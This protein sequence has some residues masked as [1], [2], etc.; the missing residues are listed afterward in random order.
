[1]APRNPASARVR[2]A[3][4]PATSKRAPRTRF[5]VSLATNIGGGR[6]FVVSTTRL[7][8]AKIALR[9]RFPKGT[10]QPRSGD[11]IVTNLKLKGA[12]AQSFH[13]F[14]TRPK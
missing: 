13:N 7:G 9:R 12:K 14:G 5:L 10:R 11:A 6:T 8:A 1:M 4:S 2:R 3:K